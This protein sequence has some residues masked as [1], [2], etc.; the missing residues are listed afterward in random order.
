[1]DT[2]EQRVAAKAYAQKWAGRGYE[3]GDTQVFWYELLQSC[4][5]IK[6]PDALAK[7]ERRTETGIPDVTI[8]VTGVIIE[9]KSLGTDLGRPQ[10]R[11]GRQVTPFEQA[12][13][14]AHSL[15]TFRERHARLCFLETITSRSI[16]FDCCLFAPNPKGCKS[17]KWVQMHPPQK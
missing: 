2:R 9:Q 10:P 14:Y 11:Q 16:Q 13:F 12:L 17:Q 1:M 8:A 7:F 15:R 6:D 3:K 5:G 4:L